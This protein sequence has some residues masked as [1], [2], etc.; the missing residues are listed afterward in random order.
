MR[1]QVRFPAKYVS[2]FSYFAL[3]HRLQVV[4]EHSY[5]ITFSV[6]DEICVSKQTFSDYSTF[7]TG[8]AH[9]GRLSL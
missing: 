4:F 8:R 7:T 3:Q 6:F 9:Y 2:L 5:F 1:S